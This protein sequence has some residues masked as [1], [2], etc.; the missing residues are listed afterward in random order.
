MSST[1]E[2]LVPKKRRVLGAVI[3]L[4]RNATGTKTR[5]ITIDQVLEGIRTGGE[6]LK[7]QITQIR[8]R[9]EAELAITGDRKNAKQAIAAL[10]KQLSGVTWSAQLKTRDKDVPLSEKLIEHSGLLCADLDS[11]GEQLPKI[12]KKLQESPHV[13]ALV[14]LAHR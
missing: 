14:P 9:Y 11:L 3:S 7:G 4:V 12:R 2:K 5:D 8:N 13:F 6:K 10:K 1:I